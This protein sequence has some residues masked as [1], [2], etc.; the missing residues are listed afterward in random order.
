MDGRL[1]ARPRYRAGR[2]VVRVGRA[3]PRRAGVRA[4]LGGAGV[5]WVLQA[6]PG[7]GAGPGG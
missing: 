2:Q 6:P 4:W 3:A 5:P 7:G 1:G